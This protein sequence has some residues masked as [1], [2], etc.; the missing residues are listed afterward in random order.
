MKV[1]LTPRLTRCFSPL[2]TPGVSISVI[3]RRTGLGIMTPSKRCKNEKPNL[4]KPLKGMSDIT[5]NELPKIVPVLIV[6]L[7]VEIFRG[8]Y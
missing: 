2:K 5:D 8:Y 1:K 7:G 3:L 4:S 6:G